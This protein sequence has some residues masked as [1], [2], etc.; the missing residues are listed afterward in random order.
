MR[1]FIRPS[2]VAALA[3]AVSALAASGRNWGP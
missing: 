3:V 2:L 1:R